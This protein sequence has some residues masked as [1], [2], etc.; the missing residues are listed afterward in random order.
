MSGR[1]EHIIDA[2]AVTDHPFESSEANSVIEAIEIEGSNNCKRGQTCP[3]CLPGG[4]LILCPDT[5]MTSTA[6]E[7]MDQD[8]NTAQQ[9]TSTNY[10]VRLPP[11]TDSNLNICGMG[12]GSES[13]CSGNLL[14]E[15]MEST[16]ITSPPILR[17]LHHDDNLVMATRT[18]TINLSE[19]PTPSVM[20]RPP[21]MQRFLGIFSNTANFCLCSTFSRDCAILLLMYIGFTVLIFLLTVVSYNFLRVNIMGQHSSNRSEHFCPYHSRYHSH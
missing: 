2:S 10:P 21:L 18:I 20:Q 14:M 1:D 16:G 7:E 9:S 4:V 8:E 11:S 3:Q 17:A 6:T 13:F 19:S 15:R 5:H 12:F